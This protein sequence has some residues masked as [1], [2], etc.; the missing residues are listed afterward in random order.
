M[1][2]RTLT[3]FLLVLWILWGTGAA[4]SQTQARLSFVRTGTTAA[5]VAIR[6]TDES[7]TDIEGAT[8]TMETATALK[9]TAENVTQDIICPNVNANTSPTIQLT[10]RIEGLPAGFTFNQVGLDIHAFNNAGKYQSNSDGVVRQWNVCVEQGTAAENLQ[11]VGTLADIDIAAGIGAAGAVHQLWN[12]SAGADIAATSP[13]IVSLVITKGSANGGCFFGLSELRLASDQAI[14]EPDPEPGE[15]GK[16][17]NIVWKNT[18]DSYMTEEADGSLDVAAYDV[19]RRQFWEFIPSGAENCFYIRNTATGRYIQSCN[20]TPASA[21]RISTGTTPVEYYVGRTAA[22]AAEISGCCWLSSTDCSGYADESAG[23]RALNKDG[24]SAFVITWQ[25]G[26]SRPGSYWRLVETDDLYEVRPFRPSAALGRAEYGYQLISESGQALQMAADGALS[27]QEHGRSDAQTWYFVGS[28]GQEGYLIANMGTGLTLG[29]AP[30]AAPTRWSCF[31][32]EAEEAAYYFRPTATRLQEGTALTIAGDSLFRIKPRRSDFALNNQIY[33]LP[34]GALGTNYIA[35][36]AI[37]GT[38]VRPMH[39][40]LLSGTDSDGSNQAARPSNWYTLY[41]KDKAQVLSGQPFT[42]TVKPAV[43]LSETEQLTAYFDWDRDGEF[44]TRIPLSGS[45]DCTATVTPPFTAPSGS[46]RIRLRLTA[47]GLLDAEDEVVGHVFDGIVELTGA[48]PEVYRFTARPNDPARGTV[49]QTEGTGRGTETFTLTAE[50]RG[51]ATFLCWREG[52]NVLSVDDSYTFE[53]DRDRDLVAIFT[54]N[55]TP[56]SSIG[57]PLIEQRAVVHIERQGQ[58][59]TVQTT[60]PLKHVSLYTPAGALVARTT[61]AHISTA[62][63][64]TGAYVV[65][66]VTEVNDADAKII[67]SH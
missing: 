4:L 22:T 42:L 20:L 56:T 54:P 34:C 32:G 48:V 10:F 53:L 52:N 49:S 26:T 50:P 3:G 5:D 15:G 46:S 27:W 25:A 29:A 58:A 31:V 7:G 36:V 55:T 39:Y 66:V 37:T 47:N 18:T 9:P 35:R 19:T 45:T 14:E 23:P 62:S 43:A 59:I 28:N 30:P 6:V 38:G 1:K 12:V 16:I 40:P 51:N 33:E 17:Y 57:T 8:A 41:T 67:V 24:A 2:K 60:A 21:S 64:P 44:E 13:L 61:A 65:K 63:M 11:S